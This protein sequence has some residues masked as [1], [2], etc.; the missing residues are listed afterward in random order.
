MSEMKKQNLAIFQKENRNFY[1]YESAKALAGAA[2]FIAGMVKKNLPL[3]AIGWAGYTSTW[4]ELMILEHG[5][6]YD[7]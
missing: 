2:V 1:R 3:A 5:H 4:I 7:D 6:E